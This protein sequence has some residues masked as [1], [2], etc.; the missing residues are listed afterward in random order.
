MSKLTIKQVKVYQSVK[1]EGGEHS[2]FIPEKFRGLMKMP[3]MSI[4]ELD[5]GQVLVKSDK[6]CIKIGHANVAFIQY[7][8]EASK[9]EAKKKA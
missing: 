4:E 3:A 7:E 2:Y 6:D 9:P 5:N 8:M 1:F